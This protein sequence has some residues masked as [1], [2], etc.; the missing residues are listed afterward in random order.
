M[1][2]IVFFG[3]CF[4]ILFSQAQIGTGQW[5]LHVSPT[6][7]I[8]VAAGNGLVVA[9]FPSGLVEYDIAAGESTLWTDV[10]SLSDVNLSALHFDPL[11]NAFW[12]GYSNG[13]IDKIKNNAVTNIPAL[14]LA[15]VQGEKNVYKFLGYNDFMY[16]STGLGILKINPNKNEVTDTYYP[17]ASASPIL[18]IAI[19]NDTIYALTST[20]VYKGFVNNI[21]LTD[22]TQWIVDDRIPVPGN[23][24][25]YKSLVAF[26]NDLFITYNKSIYGQDSV[27]RIK[28]PNL[29]MVVGAVYNPEITGLKVINNNLYVILDGGILYYDN[30]FSTVNSINTYAFSTLFKSNGVAFANGV[31]YIADELSGLVYY[32]NYIDNKPLNVS[33]PPKN[34]FFTLGGAK[35]K[36]AVAG[37][38]LMQAGFTYNNS[39]AYVLQDENWSL[40][41]IYNQP[42]WQG[43]SVWD[44]NSVSVNPKNTD[45][46]AIGAYCGEPLA[47]ATNGKQI[48]QVYNATNSLLEISS[49]GNNSTCVTDVEYDE[50]G[51]LWI[52]N[53]LSNKPLKVKTADGLWYAFDLGAT[54]K[55]KL[56]GKMVIDYNKNKWLNILNA[57][58]YGYNDGGT[59]SDPSDDQYKLINSGANTGALPSDNITA[60][61]VDFDNEIWIGT[62]NG[63]AILY[64]SEGVFDA[65]PG[66][67]NAQRI[68]LEFEGNVEYLLGSTY[69]TDIEVDGGNRKWIGTANTGIF[70][71]SA[72]GLE[73]LQHYTVENSPMISNNV[74]D[75]QINQ[76]TGEMFIIT[77]KGLLSLRI[78]AS[79]EDP[80]YSD[81]Q[82]FPNPV[83]PSF[84]GPV[85]IQGIKYNSDVKVTDVAG[86]L[87]YK[88]TSNGGTA[89]WNCKNLNGERVQT[90]VYLIW[91]TPNDGKGRKVGKVTIIN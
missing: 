85:T 84:F 66:G 12:I 48:D 79:Y 32:N 50:D 33:G 26:D 29:E 31:H 38:T 19:L 17:N 54:S 81:V 18:E 73:I 63:F 74:M 6:N 39:G 65:L 57:G 10:N 35:D 20:K 42:A 8:D 36:I 64:N 43:A 3:C 9:A 49:L 40:F 45:E 55:S 67:Y 51:N 4:A 52:A 82:V 72:D 76:V 78:D 16:V 22:P 7:T 70:L 30:T 61:A 11:S 25:S 41:D 47:I 24:A 88:T 21:S 58:L 69:I 60:I 34:S 59:I 15:S 27:F 1:K 80:E 14:K 91:T 37:G 13:N 87:V 75:M 68:K 53:G 2:F 62:D 86:N 77:D 5:R 44:I 89:T 83:M 71:L 46:V 28:S 23:D 56:S 90:G